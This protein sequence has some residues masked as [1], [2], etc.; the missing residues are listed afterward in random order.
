M[1]RTTCSAI[2]AM[3]RPAAPPS[4]PSSRLSVSS[5]RTSRCQLA[6]SAVRTA[7]SF[8]RPVARVSSRLATLAHAISSTSVT[9][10]ST[11]STA[12][13]TS[14]TTDSTSGTTS[15]VKVRSRLS[16]SRMRPA[17]AATSAFACAIVT[18][19]FRRA[20]TLKFSSPRRFDGVGA[21]RQRQEDVHLPDA[22]HGRHDLVVQQELRPEHAGHFE[23]V[24]RRRRC[25]APTPFNV[26][27]LPTMFGSAPNTRFQKP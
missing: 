7:I 19:G 9:D 25:P 15:M 27:V 14:P 18:P 11:T 13:R 26:I 3:T 23:L 1:V 16:F 21:E 10:P 24:L 17:M 8:C 12:S 4:R 6:P 20:M 22:G 2:F 5:W